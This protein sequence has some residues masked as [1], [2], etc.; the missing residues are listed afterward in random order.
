MTGSTTD[1]SLRPL[2][3]RD[4]FRNVRPPLE[5]V[6]PGLLTGT[7]GVVV[8]P[9]GTGKSMLMLSSALSV[10]IGLDLGSIWGHEIAQGRVVYLAAEDPSDVI[11]RRV[12]TLGNL[13]KT[14]EEEDAIADA[15][16][17]IPAYGRGFTIATPSATGPVPSEV[18][19]RFSDWLLKRQPRLLILDTL[20]RCLGGIS[21]ND[22]G[23][24]GAVLSIVERT[25][26]SV[27]C[28]VILVHHTNKA[29]MTE[30]SGSEQHAARGSS[31]ITDNARWQC[32]LS[33]MGRDDAAARGI[34]DDG[35]R[36]QWVRLD[37]S[38]VNYSAPIAE[39]W[40]KRGMG[41]VLT[42]DE[43]VPQRVKAGRSTAKANGNGSRRSKQDM[44]DDD[45][46]W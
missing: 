18:W 11:V 46:V 30:G 13:L 17:V 31:A 1:N 15:V 36:R 29:S 27:G 37:L 43:E 8:S 34:T 42:A 24:M 2:D 35:E 45:A 28:A 21:E 5:F 16:D 10:G 7:V 22:S 32:N 25:C 12:H 39:R 44:S 20:N 4:A 23:S 41:G 38:K 9:G 3:L 33:V 6:L 14:E 40:L 26:R 19:L